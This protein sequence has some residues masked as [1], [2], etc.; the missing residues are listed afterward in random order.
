LSP[1]L[2]VVFAKQPLVGAVKTRMTPPLSAAEAAELYGR[3]LDD[4]LEVSAAAAREVGLEPVLAVHPP[5]AVGVLARRAPSPFRAVAQRGLGLAERMTWAVG[6]AG[7]AGSWPVL[8]RGSDSPMLSPRVV[9]D[10]TAALR[11]VDVAIV[12]DRDGGYSLIGLR[13]P[14]PGLFDHPMSTRTV[15]DDTRV[16]AERLGLRTRLLDACFDL[17]TVRDLRWLAEARAGAA[18][19]LCSRTLA[20]LDERDLWQHLESPAH[21]GG[22]G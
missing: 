7:A 18:A 19:A 22:S 16:S 12:P 6:E 11:E 8:L 5:R 21:D 10:A 2:L 15:A 9:A 20:Y 4:V 13:R 17:D 3:M 14:A 1:G